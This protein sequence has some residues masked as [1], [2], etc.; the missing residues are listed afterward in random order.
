MCGSS[1]VCPYTILACRLLV[2][3]WAK[4]MDGT[5]DTGRRDERVVIDSLWK[6]IWQ[7]LCPTSAHA[8]CVHI[9]KQEK[10]Q[11]S[12]VTQDLYVV[13]EIFLSRPGKSRKSGVAGKPIRGQ[14]LT[15]N[16]PPTRGPRYSSVGKVSF[17]YSCALKVFEFISLSGRLSFRVRGCQGLDEW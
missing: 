9:H 7:M 2:R 10:F 16:A 14:V 8:A 17:T 11:V 13:S 5:Y 15:C 3:G 6:A 4:D 1:F 12:I